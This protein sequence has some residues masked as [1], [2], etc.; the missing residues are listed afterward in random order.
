M[1]QNLVSLIEYILKV[2]IGI[3]ITTH[4]YQCIHFLTYIIYLFSL[5]YYR[6]FVPN[7]TFGAT[8]V[9]WLTKKQPGVFFGKPGE[10]KSIYSFHCL[11]PRSAYDGIRA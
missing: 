8:M 4:L 9:K 6:H 7:I 11:F 10:I 5:Y 2:S 1:G 3:G